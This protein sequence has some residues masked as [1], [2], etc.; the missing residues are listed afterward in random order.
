MKIKARRLL[1]EDVPP[2]PVQKDEVVEPCRIIRIAVSNRTYELLEKLS[3]YGVYGCTIAD[4]AARLID[5]QL[6]QFI[7]KPRL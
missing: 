1:T 2:L 7:E 5:Q 6:Q 3:G 4:V